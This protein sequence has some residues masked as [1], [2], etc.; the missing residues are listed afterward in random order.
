MIDGRGVEGGRAEGFDALVDLFK[1]EGVYVYGENGRYAVA[2]TRGGE[3]I[4]A[5]IPRRNNPSEE[6]EIR[7]IRVTG[8]ER[9]I[10]DWIWN[11]CPEDQSE[12]GVTMAYVDRDTYWERRGS[13]RRLENLSEVDQ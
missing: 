6:E 13:E 9:R 4:M 11:P 5:F 10:G 3:A 2:P 7:A 8:T 1:G 12:R